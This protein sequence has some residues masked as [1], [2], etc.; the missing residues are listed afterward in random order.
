MK[1]I[2]Q[3]IPEITEPARSHAASPEPWRAQYEWVEEKLLASPRPA[4]P[5][6]LVLAVLSAS[7]GTE[8]AGGRG[9]VGGAKYQNIER[10]GGPRGGGG[11]VCLSDSEGPFLGTIML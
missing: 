4:R 8:E 11:P 3:K 1:I 5:E 2:R 7:P 9:E 6:Q 10:S